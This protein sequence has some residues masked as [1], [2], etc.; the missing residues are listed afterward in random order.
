MKEGL[1]VPKQ[2]SG[3]SEVETSGFCGKWVMTNVL[4]GHRGERLFAEADT[5]ERVFPW[6]RHGKGR[7]LLWGSWSTTLPHWEPE[8]WLPCPTVLIFTRMNW[9]AFHCVVELCLWWHH[10]EKLSKELLILRLLAT[11][12]E[13]SSQLA[14][15]SFSWIELPLLNRAWCL[16]S[17]QGCSC[18][19]TA[20]VCQRTGLRTTKTGITPKNCFWTGPLHP[21]S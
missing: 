4:L 6:S 5:G 12:S 3:K 2:T 19:F 8:H 18:W 11:S 13:D 21:P 9:S 7:M 10:R 17:P 16:P 15:L 1:Q 14:S 20:G